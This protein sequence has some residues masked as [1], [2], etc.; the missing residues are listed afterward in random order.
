MTTFKNTNS[1]VKLAILI[2]SLITM[3]CGV[4]LK[5]KFIIIS[6]SIIYL[7]VPTIESIEVFIMAKQFKSDGDNFNK[8]KEKRSK[9]EEYLGMLIL[10][11][12]LIMTGIES[13]PGIDIAG[14]IIWIGSVIFYFL[15][16]IIIDIVADIPMTMGHG[17]WRIRNR[18]RLNK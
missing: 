11:A 7:F 13:P 8:K 4:I 9:A 17:G 6:G 16:G 3:I 12:G 1:K 18:K 5:I 15:F 14:S 10:I 2:L